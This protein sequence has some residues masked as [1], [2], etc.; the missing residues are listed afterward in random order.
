VVLLSDLEKM[1]VQMN[2]RDHYYFRDCQSTWIKKWCR[3]LISLLH[4]RLAKIHFAENRY[5]WKDEEDILEYVKLLDEIGAKCPRL[6]LIEVKESLFSHPPDDIK[7]K[8]FLPAREA[9]FRALPKL[10][11]LQ[12]VRLCFIMCDDWALQQ[13]ALHGQNIV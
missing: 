10:V 1:L 3:F 7:T 4:N 8:A 5:S 11:N 2:K 12:V 13:F 6:R 9:F